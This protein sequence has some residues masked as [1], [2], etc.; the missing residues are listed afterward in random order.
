MAT[1][2]SP[3]MPSLDARVRGNAAR[4]Q[5]PNVQ[6]RRLNASA[7]VQLDIW[8]GCAVLQRWVWSRWRLEEVGAIRGASRRAPIRRANGTFRR[9][10]VHEEG[11]ALD[12]MTYNIAQGSQIADDLVY[13][14]RQ[15]QIQL[16][17]WRGL[18]WTSTN[19]FVTYSGNNAHTDHVHF[20]ISPE[21][22]ASAGG[23]RAATEQVAADLAAR[24][25]EPIIVP[26]PP[27]P[28]RETS[29]A[30]RTQSQNFG[31]E[32]QESSETNVIF[33]LLFVGGVGFAAWRLLRK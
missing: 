20:E 22:A 13:Y 2:E 12:A 27:R 4:G 16:V 32:K 8:P 18:Q 7:R 15:L 21:L 30:R 10:D 24:G 5:I 29:T 19:G 33:P 28:A 23:M 14:C 26:R 17:I 31:L 3:W 6:G 25:R 1:I 9:R 11:R